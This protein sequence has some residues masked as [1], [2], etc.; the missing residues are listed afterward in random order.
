MA[1]IE[2]FAWTLSSFL[3]ISFIISLIAVSMK[4]R[5][6]VNKKHKKS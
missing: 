5:Y 6:I 1:S 2:L 3:G 4:P